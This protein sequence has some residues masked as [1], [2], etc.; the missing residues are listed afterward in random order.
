M[1]LTQAMLKAM[2]IE[3]DKR[4]EI[5]NAH[6]RVLEDIKK[7][8]NEISEQLAEAKE[9]AAKVTELQKQLE[10][11][12]AQIPSEDWHAKYDEVVKDFEAYKTQ[13]EADRA[14]A[15]KKSLYRAL[16]REVGVDE[17]RIDAIVKVTDMGAIDVSEGAIAEP[18]ALKE[19]LSKEWAAFIPQKGEEGASV[20]T[21][22]QVKQTG[23]GEN[24][25]VIKRLQER[26]ERMYGKTED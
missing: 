17:K 21:P 25:E 1:S 3:D 23:P 20:D 16:L 18:E 26:H 8:R 14:E 22:P 10:E 13:A 2:G 24:P 11:A 4:E 15:E 5:L 6:Q 7:E 19:S 12:K 9:E